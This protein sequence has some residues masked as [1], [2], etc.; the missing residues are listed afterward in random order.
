MHDQ[1]GVHAAALEQERRGQGVVDDEQQA[2]VAAQPA[3]AFEVGDLRHRVGDRLDEHVHPRGRGDGRL[4]PLRGVQVASTKETAMPMPCSVCI[5]LLVL[6][7]SVAA[8][9][10]VVA[11][12]QQRQEDGRDR[13]HA[14][15]GST[16]C[17]GRL[18]V[19]LSPWPRARRAGRVA[20]AR[21]DGAGL[22]ALEHL[23]EI[24]GARGSSKAALTCSGL[25]EPPPPRRRGGRSA[26]GGWS[27]RRRREAGWGSR[28]AAQVGSLL[29]TGPL[30]RRRDGADRPTAPVF[31]PIADRCGYQGTRPIVRASRSNTSTSAFSPPSSTSVGSSRDPQ[32]RRR[33]PELL[34]VDGAGRQRATGCT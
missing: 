5:R 30:A 11:G 29:R 32:R 3:D 22:D 14:G 10:D 15:G 27:W 9:D 23:G 8:A 12:A 17:R 7:N 28:G 21:M 19:L 4:A 26:A 2:H 24:A 18:P 1:A 16:R 31:R 33:R 6:P 25:C 20:L 13:R 34:A